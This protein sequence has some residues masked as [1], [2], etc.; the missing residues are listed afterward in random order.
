MLFSLIALAI[1]YLRGSVAVVLPIERP[2]EQLQYDPKAEQL[3]LG[4]V[5][6]KTNAI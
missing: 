1:V 4:T 5:R 2:G 6:D 3:F